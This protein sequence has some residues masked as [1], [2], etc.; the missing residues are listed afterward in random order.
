MGKG[1]VMTSTELERRR[2]EGLKW[3]YIS[4][5][6]G[7]IRQIKENYRGIESPLILYEKP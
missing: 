2:C 3:S 1:Y 6:H 7:D 5:F 4:S